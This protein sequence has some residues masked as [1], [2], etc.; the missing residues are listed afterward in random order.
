MSWDEY[1]NSKKINASGFKQAEPEKFEELKV[2]F[3]QVHPASFTEQ[4][5]FLINMIRRKYPLSN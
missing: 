1:C 2:L 4:K 5:K 3:E